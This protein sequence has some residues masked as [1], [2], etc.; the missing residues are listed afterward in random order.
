MAERAN[1]GETDTPVQRLRQE[2]AAY[3]AR[4]DI[5]PWLKQGLLPG[6]IRERLAAAVEAGSSVGAEIASH[7]NRLRDLQLGPEESLT[8]IRA[9]A[10]YVVDR[11]VAERERGGKL[12]K[13]R[14]DDIDV[15][16]VPAKTFARQFMVALGNQ[17]GWK[18]MEV[19]RR[20]GV[21]GGSRIP[22]PI[23]EIPSSLE[24]EEAAPLPPDGDILPWIEPTSLLQGHAVH[25]DVG[26]GKLSLVRNPKGIRFLESLLEEFSIDE[27]QRALVTACA[28]ASR[29]PNEN[30]G[31]EGLVRTHCVYARSP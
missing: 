20:E 26:L 2:M 19:K 16:G 23:A 3:N 22:A 1:G 7:L 21:Y 25:F 24:R 18:S 11:Y 17:V 5:V 27:V 14:L 30:G 8:V 6:D 9:A 10:N 12:S 29:T 28:R 4:R 15:P 13:E 31:L